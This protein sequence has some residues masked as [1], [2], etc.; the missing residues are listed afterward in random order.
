MSALKAVCIAL[1][2]GEAHAAGSHLLDPKTGEYNISYIRH[3]MPDIAVKVVAMVRREQGLLVRRGN[4]KNI[5]A[6]E[7][8]GS[9]DVSFVNRQRGAGTRVLLDY[10]L[11]LMG[12][13]DEI[14][15]RVQ[16]RRIYTSRRCCSD[17]IRAVQTVD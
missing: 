3:Y 17:S 10:H 16:S 12:I 6:L 15:S 2:R 14:N 8:L 4:P 13:S 5:N 9:K 1:R 11:Q 7:D